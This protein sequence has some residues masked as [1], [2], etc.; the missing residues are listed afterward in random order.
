MDHV[1]FCRIAEP[2]MLTLERMRLNLATRRNRQ[3][4]QWYYTQLMDPKVIIRS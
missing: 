3:R 2:F 4:T 1:K